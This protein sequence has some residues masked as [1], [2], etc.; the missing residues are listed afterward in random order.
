MTQNAVGKNEVGKIAQRRSIGARKNPNAE[1]A[2]LDAALTLL[3]SKGVKGL[4][5]D[6]VAKEAKAG[7]A[8]IYRWWPTR[9]ALLL[10]IYARIKGPHTHSDTGHIETDIAAFLDYVF[11]F[12]RGDAGPVFALIIAEAQ[13]D[14][15]V[16]EAL[17]Q[18][19]AERIKDWLVVIDRAAERGELNVTLEREQIADA[20]IAVAWHHLLTNRLHVKGAELVQVLGFGILK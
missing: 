12:W 17:A 19:R 7:K 1:A 5:M 16:A 18:Y 13:S 3:Q 2:I 15:S 11:E 14:A 6:A 4:T 9:G 8:T 10:G 20:I